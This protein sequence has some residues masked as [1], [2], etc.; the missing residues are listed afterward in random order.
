MRPKKS[1]SDTK[2]TASKALRSGRKAP[3]RLKPSLSSSRASPFV[4]CGFRVADGD[5]ETCGYYLRAHVRARACAAVRKVMATRG[6]GAAAGGRRRGLRSSAHEMRAAQKFSLR[7]TLRARFG[8]ACRRLQVLRSLQRACHLRRRRRERAGA[9]RGFDVAAIEAEEDAE[10]NAL[11][12]TAATSEEAGS[13]DES[14]CGPHACA[15]A[16]SSGDRCADFRRLSAAARSLVL[17]LDSFDSFRA[18]ALALV[19]AIVCKVRDAAT[20]AAARTGPTDRLRITAASMVAWWLLRDFCG[21][22]LGAVEVV[23]DTERRITVDDITMINL[24]CDR[25]AT[26]VLPE[27]AAAEGLRGRGAEASRYGHLFGCRRR[28]DP[29]QSHFGLWRCGHLRCR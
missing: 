6:R 23:S 22:A 20:A 21:S 11:A 16:L 4:A 26:M 19:T 15:L 17:D 29:R 8:G 9:R 10:E 7:S 13:K 5:L 14:D 25:E 28:L 1:N 18:S 27:Y 12:S 2:S 3:N 24:G